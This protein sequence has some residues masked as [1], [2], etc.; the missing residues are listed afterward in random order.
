M[1]DFRKLDMNFSGRRKWM[2]NEIRL[3]G[4]K[5]QCQES[6]LAFT[7]RLITIHSDCTVPCTVDGFHMR[8]AYSFGIVLIQ[9][10]KR[11]ILYT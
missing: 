9:W 10:C 2:G 5:V 6:E 1:C 8:T 4:C 3:S 11:V 7:V